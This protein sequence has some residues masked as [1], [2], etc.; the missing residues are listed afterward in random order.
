MILRDLLRVLGTNGRDGRNLTS[1]EAYKA[2]DSIL[3]GGESEIR[4]GAFLI[5]LR[6]KGASVEELTA[7]SRAARAR[8]TIPCTDLDELVCVCP[9]HDGLERFPPLEVAAG[10]AAA[11]AGM[12]VLIISDRCVPPKRGLTVASVLEELDIHL[13]FNPHEAEE[14][15]AKTR[16]AAM[17]ASGMLPNLLALRKVRGD[18]GV[19][20]PLATV[21]KLLAPSNAAILI[22]AQAGP[23]LGG[24]VEVLQNLGH[25]GA[26]AV[27][28]LEGG[29]VPSVRKRSR[30][31]E[32]TK[33]HQAPL[34]IE[35]EDYGLWSDIDPELPLYGP[36]EDGQGSGDIAELRA[37][38]AQAT[39][40]VLTGDTGPER[41]ATL[42]SAAL[43]LRAG[44][45]AATIADGVS[46]A[47]E[48]IDS[49]EA[50]AVLRRLQ[51]LA[52]I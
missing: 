3:S 30:S 12:R 47:A 35:P 20:T 25:P 11:G 15:V 8:A 10:L 6:I 41:S 17:A 49:G 32:L 36:P 52:K 44:G 21:E 33:T 23:V 42:L 9:P 40:R 34:R 2:F 50:S 29:V 19:R 13:T 37:A 38:S 27:Q 48:S 4:I 1:E 26:I 43:M 31:I 22:G 5:A 24:A 46:M 18:I 16:F 28:G 7:F 45:R 51:E 14:W 39:Q